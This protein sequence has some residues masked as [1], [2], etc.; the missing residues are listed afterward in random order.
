MQIEAQ[1]AHSTR[2]RHN[3]QK[4]IEQVTKDADRRRA[5]LDSLRRDLEV[6]RNAA[7]AAQEAQRRA[8]QGSLALSEEN[9]EEY[10]RLCV[11]LCTTVQQSLI[12]SDKKTGKH[13]LVS[14]R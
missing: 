7:D 3:A 11:A 1:I 4:M 8:A 5:K 10:R 2:K 13:R 9:L 14:W 6:V 12:L